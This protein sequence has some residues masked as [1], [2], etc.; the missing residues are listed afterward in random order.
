MCILILTNVSFV[1][2]FVELRVRTLIALNP[3]DGEDDDASQTLPACY[4]WATAGTDDSSS[5]L[6]SPTD[7]TDTSSVDLASLAST[8]HRYY[9][10]ETGRTSGIALTSSCSHKTDTRERYR[11]QQQQQPPKSVTEKPKNS[12]FWGGLSLKHWNSSAPPE[13]GAESE[14]RSLSE[15][16]SI[17]SLT[18]AV[19][20]GTSGGGVGGGG[21]GALRTTALPMPMPP[22]A[23]GTNARLGSSSAYASASTM[24]RESRRAL[25]GRKLKLPPREYESFR[26]IGKK[27]DGWDLF[28]ALR[29]RYSSN[30]PNAAY[31]TQQLSSR[32]THHIRH[33][34]G[35]CTG[36]VNGSSNGS[37][38]RK[39]SYRRHR[40]KNSRAEQPLAILKSM[41]YD[42]TCSPSR[43]TELLLL[44]EFRKGDIRL[45]VVSSEK[46]QTGGG[47]GSEDVGGGDP[48]RHSSDELHTSLLALQNDSH[49]HSFEGVVGA[50]TKLRGGKTAR[51]AGSRARGADDNLETAAAAAAAAGGDAGADADS[52]PSSTSTSNCTSDPRSRALSV[53]SCPAETQVMSIAAAAAAAAAATEA[54]DA[55]TGGA[56][57][58]SECI[59]GGAG[60][61]GTAQFS[62]PTKRRVQHQPRHHQHLPLPSMPSI[63][64]ED[65]F[66]EVGS[67]G[68]SAA[69]ARGDTSGRLSFQRRRALSD[70]D[71]DHSDGAAR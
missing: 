42:E 20:T 37:V 61:A 59:W 34:T 60:G 23:H 71:K 48:R 29:R 57:S 45:S 5:R 38:V 31:H 32:R 33:S 17:A 28:G 11:Q 70:G 6:Q 21:Y 12:W 1:F 65:G 52:S 69:A 53:A 36:T 47:A 30:T 50:R 22:T 10:Q 27:S 18:S 40:A 35:A 56:G 7:F 9:Q 66:D 2:G 51:G 4:R 25:K 3:S 14:L 8:S 67:S 46:L 43:D 49:S 54:V 26:D 62:S 55:H 13:V 44:P 68:R 39:S 41:S 58:S 16:D 63:L 24:Q 64:S 19:E 15:A